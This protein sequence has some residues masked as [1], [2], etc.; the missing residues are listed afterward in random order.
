MAPKK[1]MD[2][3]DAVSDGSD[4]DSSSSEAEEEEEKHQAAKRQKGDITLGKEHAT[5]QV[6]NNVMH[7][8]TC[9][10]P[11]GM[12]GSFGT[13]FGMALPNSSH[14]DDSV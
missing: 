1:I 11:G 10:T 9:C 14:I 3:L 13:Q 12:W 5:A 7:S 6:F 8:S 4:A 2:A